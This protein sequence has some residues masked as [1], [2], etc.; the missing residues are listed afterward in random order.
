[1]ITTGDITLS[2]N[3]DRQCGWLY[4]ECSVGNSYCVGVIPS[5]YV[6]TN[7]IVTIPVGEGYVTLEVNGINANDVISVTKNT[8]GLSVRR[9]GMMF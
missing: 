3:F 9:L 1:M 7:R 5:D 2:T 6:D 8:S 4:V